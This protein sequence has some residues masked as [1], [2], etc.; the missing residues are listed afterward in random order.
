MVRLLSC[1][2]T[3]CL[4]LS[5]CACNLPRGGPSANAVVSSFKKRIITINEAEAIRISKQQFAEQKRSIEQ[6][7]NILSQPISFSS[8]RINAGDE[9]VITLTSY[10]AESNIDPSQDT[11]L[12]GFNKRDLGHFIVNQ[13]GNINLPYIGNVNVRGL[14]E[15]QARNVIQS[16]YEQANVVRE[17]YIL[18]YS[19]KNKQNDITVTGD[20][21]S[22]KIIPWQPGGIKLATA[23][24]LAQSNNTNMIRNNSQ[25]L[26]TNK[27]T[28][29][30]IRDQQT[31][32]LPYDIALRSNIN[33]A[34]ADKV[35][36]ESS[37][38]VRATLLGGGILKNGTYNFSIQPSLLEA[39]AQAGG[40][41]VYNANISKVFVLRKNIKSELK[42][43]QFAFNKGSGLAAASFFPIADRDVIF[44]PEAGIVPWLRITNIAFQMALPAA[45]LK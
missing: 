12:A 17:P 20:I 9:L 22:P 44:A 19:V 31:Y 4:A 1:F 18:L 13:Q 34:P 28:I 3:I 21:G 45:V 30:I 38:E 37:P 2:V 36:V 32:S 25:K 15:E 39:L 11:L 35:I 33:L 7:L 40:F 16:Q 29:N 27:I 23:L 6:S 8:S 24:T 42:I 10:S 14:T 5:L 41:N 26:N 43:Y